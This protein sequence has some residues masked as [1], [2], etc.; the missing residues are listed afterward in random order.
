MRR[1]GDRLF[2]TAA[3]LTAESFAGTVGGWEHQQAIQGE[4]TAGVA[5][6]PPGT[7]HPHRLWHREIRPGRRL[8]PDAEERR[9][10]VGA[11]CAAAASSPRVLSS[12]PAG[13]LSRLGLPRPSSRKK[14]P[15]VSRPNSDGAAMSWIAAPAALAGLLCLAGGARWQV[16]LQ[17]SVLLLLC[18]ARFKTSASAGEGHA[19]LGACVCTVGRPAGTALRLTE[20]LSAIT[21]SWAN[22]GTNAYG[23]VIAAFKP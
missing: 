13:D 12:S 21:A 19:G 23:W 10:A 2:A 5:G 7:C 18:A 20:A 22:V 11:Q 4:A 14:T 8:R 16:D 6:M 3:V 1:S 15:P 9:G 17:V